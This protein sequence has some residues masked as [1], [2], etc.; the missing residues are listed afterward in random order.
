MRLYIR[1]S[2][3]IPTNKL[4]DKLIIAGFARR[5]HLNMVISKGRRD[6]VNQTHYDIIKFYSSRIRGILNYYSFAGNYG[7]VKK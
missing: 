6:L 1:I 2:V 4:I 5:N 3:V 7:H